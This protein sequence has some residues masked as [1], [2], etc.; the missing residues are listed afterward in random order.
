MKN[1]SIDV[2]ALFLTVVLLIPALVTAQPPGGVPPGAGG[3]IDDLQNQIN[4]EEA[5]RIAGDE[6]EHQ[7]HIDG[8]AALQGAID[9]ES[10]ARQSTDAALQGAIDAESAAR[11][12]TDAALQGAIDAESAARQNTDAALQGAIDAEEA[13]RIAGDE[14]EAAARAAI[15]DDIQS[16]IDN[17]GAGCPCWN[18]EMLNALSQYIKDPTPPQYV[19][20]CQDRLPEDDNGR[21]K[22]GYAFLDNTVGIMSFSLRNHNG[23]TTFYESPTG[24]ISIG[25]KTPYCWTRLTDTQTSDWVNADSTTS[26]VYFST[27][28]PVLRDYCV[29]CPG[30]G[31]PDERIEITSQEA[32]ACKEELINSDLWARCD[33][34]LP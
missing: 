21:G 13:A 18:K 20:R 33:T 29:G 27:H 15:D 8:D 9:A 17:M 34:V 32:Y 6:T 7:H 30:K 2:I 11:Q 25:F 24:I 1:L 26:K 12:N 23:R 22:T 14:A 28:P 19:D 3:L 4:D 31:T 10:A 5:A 16:Q